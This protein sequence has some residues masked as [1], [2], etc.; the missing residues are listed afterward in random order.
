MYNPLQG[1]ALDL[2]GEK[3]DLGEYLQKLVDATNVTA[4]ALA[5]LT[6]DA[7]Y[8][9]APA[10]ETDNNQTEMAA[11]QFI[12][13]FLYYQGAN[14]NP[15]ENGHEYIKDQ[16]L[17]ALTVQKEEEKVEPAYKLGDADGNGVVNTIDAML[18][19]QYFAKLITADKLTVPA[20]D[21]DG[22]G[23]VNTIDAM[24]IMQYFAKLINKFPVEA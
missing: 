2:N 3:L 24:L 22:N 13:E 6:G 1:V 7:I 23:V 20:C 18:V 9:D 10:V 16:I 17:N 14:L 11:T 19:M 5:M 15:N 12:T 21:V 4:L 8:V